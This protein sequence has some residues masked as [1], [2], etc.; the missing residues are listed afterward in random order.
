[1]EIRSSLVRQVISGAVSVDFKAVREA[2]ERRE[3]ESSKS[4]HKEIEK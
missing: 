4:E 1:M 2:K 3:L